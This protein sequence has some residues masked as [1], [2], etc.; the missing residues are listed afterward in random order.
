MINYIAIILSTQQMQRIQS[1]L[2]AIPHH[3]CVMNLEGE[4]ENTQIS[5]VAIY[6]GVA[7]P[8]RDLLASC[9]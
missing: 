2:Q 7:C 6:L 5:I 8:N 3:N 1:I 4:P 9:T